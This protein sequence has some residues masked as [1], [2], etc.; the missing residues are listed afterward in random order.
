MSDGTER[1]GALESRVADWEQ[2]LNRSHEQLR[3][4]KITLAAAVDRL[5]EEFKK[6]RMEVVNLRGE[7]R[8]V[9][10]TLKAR[11]KRKVTQ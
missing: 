6:M 7:V 10:E 2:I 3:G 11:K 1:L 9:A 4:E 5:V 8:A